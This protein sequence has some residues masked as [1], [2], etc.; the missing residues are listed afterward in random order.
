MK[1]CAEKYIDHQVNDVV[2]LMKILSIDFSKEMQSK[3]QKE[4]MLNL[5]FKNKH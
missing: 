2:N 1:T 3:V 4:G 5:Q